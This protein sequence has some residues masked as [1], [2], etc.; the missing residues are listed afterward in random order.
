MTTFGNN[1]PGSSVTTGDAS[2][3]ET[4][5]EDIAR[6]NTTLFAN[7]AQIVSPNLMKDTGM[8]RSAVESAMQNRESTCLIRQR[9]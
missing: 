4:T 8:R 7:V 5:V 9:S 2:A 6:S 3:K 1:N